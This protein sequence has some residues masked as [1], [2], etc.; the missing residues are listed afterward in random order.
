MLVIS[1]TNTGTMDAWINFS[2]LH[3]IKPH[4]SPSW[5]FVVCFR[6]IHKKNGFPSHTSP[7]LLLEWGPPWLEVTSFD[8]CSMLFSKVVEEKV[9]KS[10]HA[11]HCILSSRPAAGHT[12]KN[13][14]KA[15]S[16]IL[17]LMASKMP[18]LPLGLHPPTPL[19]HLQRELS[20]NNAWSF[21]FFFF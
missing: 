14:S 4:I 18:L 20:A 3:T 2:S 9:G 7:R 16:N 8:L 21:F 15:H 13:I 1:V 17:G 10:H 6:E 11:D 12:R 19:F 5:L